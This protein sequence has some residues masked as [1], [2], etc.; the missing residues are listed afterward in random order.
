[1]IV[2]AAREV[3]VVQCMAHSVL[4]RPPLTLSTLL[5]IIL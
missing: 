4:V 2:I 3:V 5:H 1:M